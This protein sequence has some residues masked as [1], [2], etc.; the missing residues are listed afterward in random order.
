MHLSVFCI[1]KKLVIKNYVL[2]M[3]QYEF[4]AAPTLPIPRDAFAVFMVMFILVKVQ[5][6]PEIGSVDRKAIEVK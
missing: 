1:R 4:A 3:C 2:G 6:P 5:Q